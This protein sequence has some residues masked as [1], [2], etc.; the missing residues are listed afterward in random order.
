[1][2]CLLHLAALSLLLSLLGCS[3]T[4]SVNAAPREHK[5]TP[6]ATPAPT[7]EPTDKQKIALL[8]AEARERG[9]KWRIFCTE[10]NKDP[11]YQFLGEA[12]FRNAPFSFY[13]EEGGKGMWLEPGTTQADAAYALYLSI[14]GAQT[15]P[16]ER[17]EPDPP[18]HRHYCPPELRG[19]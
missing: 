8:R 2:R 14:Q 19:D 4:S 13:K 15:H 9:L 5:P 6:A 10:W 12:T 11:R 7:P 18:E 3:G 17:K 1:V 16:A